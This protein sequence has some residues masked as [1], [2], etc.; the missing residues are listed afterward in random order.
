MRTV[1]R[2]F[3]VSLSSFRCFVS[4]LLVFVFRIRVPLV[5]SRDYRYRLA[6]EKPYRLLPKFDS[7]NVAIHKA[8]SYDNFYG[9]LIGYDERSLVDIF[10]SF[11]RRVDRSVQ[12]FAMGP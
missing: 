8:C 4:K 12:N 5:R 3:T 6:T 11:G 1:K 2:S 9:K 10:L 7:V